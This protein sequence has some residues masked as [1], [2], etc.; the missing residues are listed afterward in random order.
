MKY[1]L[2]L[3]AVAVV[4]VAAAGTYILWPKEAHTN[5][6][7]TITVGTAVF[8]VEVADTEGSRELGL[9]GRQTLP[10][11]QGMLFIFDKPGAWGFWM[12]DTK[13]PLDILWARQD[14]TVTTIAR[15]VAPSTYPKV[16]YPKAPDAK[17]VLEVS[18]GAAEGIAE[19]T[20]MMVQ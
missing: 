2:A 15:N 8:K 5:V 14:G 17:Y 3:L 13:F 9:G 4:A 20:Q 1:W 12:K 16:F 10:Q 18:A 7:Q 11:G 19:G 6:V